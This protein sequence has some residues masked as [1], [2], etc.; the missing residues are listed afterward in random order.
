LEIAGNGLDDDQLRFLRDLPNLKALNLS[1]N[2][3]ITDIGLSH[4]SKIKN[5]TTLLIHDINNFTN[6]GI[7][8]LQYLKNL[9]TWK[10]SIADN[11]GVTREGIQRLFSLLGRELKKYGSYIF[12]EYIV[13]Y[14]S[15]DFCEY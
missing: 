10:I 3:T 4:V 9:K 5:L 8:Q 14:F 15:N 1:G 7:L 2:K 11:N 12:K 6:D 13:E